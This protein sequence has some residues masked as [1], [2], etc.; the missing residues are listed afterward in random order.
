VKPSTGEKASSQ[1][2]SSSAVCTIENCITED[3]NGKLTE[4]T[5]KLPA[6]SRQQHALSESEST[7]QLTH[8]PDK[9]IRVITVPR[10]QFNLFCR[11]KSDSAINCSENDMFAVSTTGLLKSGKWPPVPYHPVNENA[12]V[13]NEAIAIDGK[14]MRKRKM[15]QDEVTNLDSQCPVKKTFDLRTDDSCQG[16][17]NTSSPILSLSFK[18]GLDNCTA[19]LSK[20]ARRAVLLQKGS[21]CPSLCVI[22]LTTSNIANVKPDQPTVTCEGGSPTFQRPVIVVKRLYKKPANNASA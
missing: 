13:Q 5:L 3:T 8:R 11:T 10:R 18:D 19:E 21:G 2:T 15:E 16:D 20:S 22:P 9:Q 7:C 4:A 12:P 17:S 1:L 6:R 14:L